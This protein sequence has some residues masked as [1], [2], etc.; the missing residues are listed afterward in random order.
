MNKDT[1]L[2]IL[3]LTAIATITCCAVWF[4]FRKVWNELSWESPEQR[5]ERKIDILL[6]KLEIEVKITND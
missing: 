4:G 5:I 6:D 1:I 3:S 2:G